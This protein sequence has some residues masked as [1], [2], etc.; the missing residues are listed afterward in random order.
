MNMAFPGESENQPSCSHT[1]SDFERERVDQ[2]TLKLDAPRRRCQAD[3]LQVGHQEE[4]EK[5]GVGFQSA[6]FSLTRGVC[7]HDVP[8]HHQVCGV[9]TDNA[10]FE[11]GAECKKKEAELERLGVS[12]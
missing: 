4:E 3:D 11:R 2:F 6:L 10:S 7:G 9:I 8:L 12:S 1:V 5:G